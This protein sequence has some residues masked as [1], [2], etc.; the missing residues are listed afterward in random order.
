MNTPGLQVAESDLVLQ[1]VVWYAEKNV[2]FI[3]AY[4]AAWML[5][6]SISKSYTFDQKHFRRFD[7][8]TAELPK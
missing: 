1:A 5:R 7:G 2:D 4:N 8:I 3:D 6:E